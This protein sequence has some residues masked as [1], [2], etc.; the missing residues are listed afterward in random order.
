MQQIEIN[1]TFHIWI[2]NYIYKYI[3]VRNAG[4]MYCILIKNIVCMHIY[5]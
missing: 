2:Y 3:F 4:Y 5:G 1:D